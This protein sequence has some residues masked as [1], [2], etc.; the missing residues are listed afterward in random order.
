MDS[1][2]K[3]RV[4][5]RS[6]HVAVLQENLLYIWGGFTLCASETLSLPPDE[7]C[8]FDAEQDTWEIFNMNGDI[9]LL[10]S[11]SCGC[12]LDGHMYI[13]GGCEYNWHTNEMYCVN[14]K[15]RTYTWKYLWYNSDSA[16]SPRDQASCWVYKGRIIYFGG[17]GEKLLDDYDGCN[18]S[19]IVDQASWLEDVIWGWNNEVHVYDPV[20]STWQEPRMFG[21]VPP[22]RASHASA[23]LGS[24][25]YIYGGNQLETQMSDIHC[26]DLES[27]TWTQITPQSSAPAGRSWHT[28]TAVSE[29]TV[30]LLG[31][32]GAGNKAMSDSWLLDVETHTWRET[33]HL[34]KNTRLWHSACSPGDSSVVVFGGSR[35]FI[36]SVFTDHCNDVLIFQLQPRSLFRICLNYM[37]NNATSSHFLRSQL[38]L[39]PPRLLSALQP[40]TLPE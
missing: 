17:Y 32:L 26:L 11:G 4:R 28:L 38:S 18:T 14:L 29:S 12:C 30:F 23:V 16:P 22:A 33:D 3:K 24:K 37:S 39:L 2:R 7:L 40:R 20:K 25:G 31:G 6:G 19:F 35:D 10:A 34:K 1:S 13:F 8:V 15:D 36:N 5:E 27:W 21:Q 9:P